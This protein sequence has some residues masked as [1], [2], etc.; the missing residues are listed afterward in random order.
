MNVSDKLQLIR[1]LEEREVAAGRSSSVVA[2]VAV[3]V[4][5][6]VLF[7]MIGFGRQELASLSRS[8]TTA[9]EELTKKETELGRKKKELEAAEARLATVKAETDEARRKL[10]NVS[11][12]G[13]GAG[14][15]ESAVDNL[16]AASLAA[17]APMTSAGATGPKSEG[18][19]KQ[20]IAQLFDRSPAV[21]VRAYGA[22]LP[23][24][25]DDVTLV[26][27]ILEFARRNPGNA[28]GI[29]NALVVLSHM[30]ATSLTPHRAEIAA[31]AEESQRL[32]PR[33]GERARTVLRRLPDKS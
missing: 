9:R 2:W 11:G 27:E 25:A 12:R 1:A 21:R 4:A 22:L 18:S 26:P 30:R 29:Y 17:G 23:Q 14:A 19:R 15:V 5:G 8:V 13:A 28:N 3:L 24:Y 10:E 32:G 33:V 20:A 16:V 6:F 31:F 7:V